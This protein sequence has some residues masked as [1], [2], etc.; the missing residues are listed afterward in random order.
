MRHDAFKV[1]IIDHIC[2]STA[3]IWRRQKR[4]S[5]QQTP[6]SQNT[7]PQNCSNYNQ[8]GETTCN[9]VAHPSLADTT[10]SMGEHPLTSPTTDGVGADGHV[11]YNPNF[12]N[13]SVRGP[14]GGGGRDAS[15]TVSG[16]QCQISIDGK[17]FFLIPANEDAAAAVQV[18]SLILIQSFSYPNL[19]I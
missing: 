13:T 14:R 7:T 6:T 18:C 4:F 19:R 16:S 8:T 11:Y 3:V 15:T 10:N 1:F 17:P 2:T 12:S 5:S 9:N